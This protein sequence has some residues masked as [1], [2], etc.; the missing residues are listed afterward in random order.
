MVDALQLDHKTWEPRDG[1]EEVILQ[2]TR[3]SSSKTTWY[4]IRIIIP[5]FRPGQRYW[6]MWILLVSP[7]TASKRKGT[8]PNCVTHF[9]TASTCEWHWN[10]CTSWRS[11]SDQN[12]ESCLVPSCRTLHNTRTST[13]DCISLRIPRKGTVNGGGH[14]GGHAAQRK[15]LVMSSPCHSQYIHHH[16]HH[17]PL[18]STNSFS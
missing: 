16:H 15:K 2:E 11:L 18:K 14:L 8:R 10:S 12:L 13:G 7:P 6:R 3:V 1:E 17:H 9:T 5:Y 4:S